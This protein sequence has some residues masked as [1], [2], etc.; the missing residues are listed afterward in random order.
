MNGDCPAGLQTVDVD[1]SLL[2]NFPIDRSVLPVARFVGGARAARAPLDRF[3][4]TRLAAYDTQR[5]QPDI[6]G[7]SQLSPY[8]HFGHISVQQV[9]LAATHASAPDLAK[10]A[11]LEE[12]IVRRELAINFVR[13]NPSYD[14]FE[15]SAPWADRSLRLHARDSRPYIYSERQLENAETHD[16]LWNAAQ[17]QMVLTGWMHGYLRMYWAKK[18]LEW[19]PAPADAFEIAVRLNDRY[20]LM[21]AIPTVTPGSPGRS[22]ASMTGPGAR[23]GQFTEKSVICPL[24]VHRAS[25]TVKLISRAW[26]R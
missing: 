18:I 23:S 11:F 22:S 6:D 24:P 17:K 15:A 25:S 1:D 16:P 21:A 2:E 13:Y 20:E 7:T 26:R 9:A 4:A 8:L 14:S 12:L 3:L 5:N 10:K 19:S